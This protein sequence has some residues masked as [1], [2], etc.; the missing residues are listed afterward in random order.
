VSDSLSTVPALSIRPAPSEPTSPAEPAGPQRPRGIP[1]KRLSAAYLGGRAF[2]LAMRL[3]PARRR[4]A[5]AARLAG[6]MAVLMRS[7]RLFRTLRRGMRLNTEH[8]LALHLLLRSMT[9]SGTPFEV[10]LQMEG[11]D[12]LNDALASGRGTV[13]VAT[14]ALLTRL[15]LRHL[16]DRGHC[17]T[18]IG[19][20]ETVP[21]TGTDVVIPTL[22]PG[23]AV[24]LAVRRR[25]LQGDLVCLVVDQTRPKPGKNLLAFETAA[26]E[27]RFSESPYRLAV[28]CNARVLFTFG[29]AEGGGVRLWIAE[30]DPASANSPRAIADDFMRFLREHIA[31]PD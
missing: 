4:F 7:T 30:P 21:L 24:L 15:L 16:H 8:D 27:V 2:G 1:A 20:M 28:L 26:G 23:P 19:A 9:A 18:V 5:G 11:E 17:P 10:P 22:A 6:G 3:V 29:H 12:I 14:H 13:I 31:Q 25:L